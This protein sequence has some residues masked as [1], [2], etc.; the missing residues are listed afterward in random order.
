[1]QGRIFGDGF[2]AFVAYQRVAL[3]LSYGV[4]SKLLEDLFGETVNQS[5][6]VLLLDRMADK[7]ANTERLLTEEILRNS[8]F[9]HVDE[10]SM[11]I[12]ATTQYIWVLTDGKHVVF[13]LTPTREAT[14]VKEML[15]DY[16][17]ANHRLLRRL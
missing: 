6:L 13:R 16:N 12:R 5:T 3:R 1:M 17:G 7:Y 14:M 2:M 11:G 10:T 4:L 9:V 8:P 15:T